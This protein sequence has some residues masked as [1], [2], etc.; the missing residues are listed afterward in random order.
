MSDTQS[1]DNQVLTTIASPEA[2]VDAKKNRAQLMDWLL[3]LTKVL[4]GGNVLLSRPN[5]DAMW[6]H[7]GLYT[8]GKDHRVYGKVGT[9]PYQP[10][11]LFDDEVFVPNESNKFFWDRQ[12]AIYSPL[13]ENF[14]P[15]FEVVKTTVYH[16]MSGTI[17]FSD[18]ERVSAEEVLKEMK[19]ELEAYGCL[20]SDKQAEG[21]VHIRA[22]VLLAAT[23]L[24][25][26]DAMLLKLAKEHPELGNRIEKADQVQLLASLCDWLTMKLA[27][28]T[29]LRKTT[30]TTLVRKDLDA[31]ENLL[32]TLESA[33][34]VDPNKL[35]SAC[36][37]ADPLLRNTIDQGITKG[38]SPTDGGDARAVTTLAAVKE[39]LRR[40][41]RNK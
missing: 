13:I 7:T 19:A 21:R 8:D 22:A 28:D 36:Y 10:L 35:L 34:G 1:L 24:P 39:E 12:F 26:L 30:G 2:V 6:E 31:A 27:D 40:R 17:A 5:G 14:D 4:E 11:G 25:R 15:A 33:T 16:D 9:S 32:A 18:G 3:T 29:L 20:D 41:I 38:A 23:K 37:L